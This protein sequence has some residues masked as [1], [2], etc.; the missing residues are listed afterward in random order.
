MKAPSKNEMARIESLLFTRFGLDGEAL[1][2]GSLQQALRQ[3]MALRE[4]HDGDAYVRQLLADKHE[5]HELVEHL[6]VPE[7]W[8]F[9]NTPSFDCLRRFVNPRDVFS[10]G[11]ERIRTASLPRAR[12]ALSRL[13]LHPHR[14]RHYSP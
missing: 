3:R 13:E 2:S 10:G 4:T 1:G 6:L 9:R 7:T 8:F 11:G 5:L 14:E 12:R